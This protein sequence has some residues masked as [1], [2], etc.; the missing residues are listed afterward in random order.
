MHLQLGEIYVNI[1]SHVFVL[2]RESQVMRDMCE[3]F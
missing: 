2:W 1:M 3:M